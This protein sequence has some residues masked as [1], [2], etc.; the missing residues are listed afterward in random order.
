MTSVAVVVVRWAGGRALRGLALAAAAGALAELANVALMATATW[1]IVRAAQQPPVVALGLAIVGVRAF[2]LSRSAFRYLERLSG[3]DAA[4]S[5]LVVLR[6]RVFAALERAVPDRL[7]SGDSLA[8]MVADV[9]AVQDLLLRSLVPVVVAAV[10]GVAAVAAC[11]VILP[12]AGLVLAAGLVTAVVVV[13][14]STWS[15]LRRLLPRVAW[16][17]AR[18]CDRYLDLAEG[19][20]ELLVYGGLGRAE[21]AAAA[22]AERLARPA[23]RAA[24]TESTAAAAI[25]VAQAGTTLAV[26]LVAQRAVA[27]VLVPVLT[28]TALT[29]FAIATPLPAAARHLAGAAAPVRRLTELLDA[30]PDH[31]E[32]THPRR[33]GPGPITA[34]LQ[35]IRVRYDAERAPALDGFD[36]RVDPGKRIALVGPSGSGKSTVLAVLSRLVQPASGRYTLAGYDVRELAATDVRARVAGAAQD[37][38]VFHAPLR[39]NLALAR[40]AA[41]DD[42]L[43]A[44]ARRARLED[45]PDG[46]DTVVGHD[47][48]LLSGGQRQRLVLAR[49]L[50]ADPEVL[51]LDEPAEG[52]D[53]PTAALLLAETLDATR[54]RAV[55]LV[56]HTLAGL[57]DVDEI[58][59]LENGRAAQRGPHAEL[60]AVPGL[61]RRLWEAERL[62]AAR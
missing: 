15:V 43:L 59:V 62:T 16:A 52:V 18:L 27:P 1:L 40:P 25:L 44:A 38:Y 7:R 36:L 55:V 24:R 22:A 57:E 12:V 11:A 3:H 41:T 46:L 9:D 58:V 5:V 61:Y 49:A 48:G 32:P 39:D 14:V 2:A 50:L 54:G 34:E 35:E 4:L 26:L 10:T 53:P 19:T 45:L 42:E 17:R 6:R 8:R 37:A 20:A 60:V 13:P 28:L 23:R 30:R 21:Q 56:T 31:T 29:A 47:G 51:L 33:L